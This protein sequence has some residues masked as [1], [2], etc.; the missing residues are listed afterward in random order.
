MQDRPTAVELLEAMRDFLE[1]EVLPELSG[2]RQFHLRVTINLLSIL[3]REWEQEDGAARKEWSRLAELLATGA[4]EPVTPAAL[5]ESVAAMNRDLSE[6]I[7]S[8]AFDDRWTE[9]I[10][11]L[12]EAVIDKLKVANPQYIEGDERTE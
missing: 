7:R 4:A 1:S 6:R 10:P 8:G 3:A 9:L 12:R 2:R 5:R 11:I